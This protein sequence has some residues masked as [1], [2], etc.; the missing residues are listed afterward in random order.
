V[1]GEETPLK[2][3]GRD[4]E[5]ALEIMAPMQPICWPPGDQHAVD[6]EEDGAD[7]V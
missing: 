2:Q 1:A 4:A 3:L 5:I 6:I 7:Q